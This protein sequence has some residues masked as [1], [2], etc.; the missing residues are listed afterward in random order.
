LEQRFPDL[1]QGDA[2]LGRRQLAQQRLL[3]VQQRL[4]AAADLG[5][6]RA[7]GLA[8][9]P[10]QLDRRRGAHLE[11][12]CRLARRSASFNR[13]NQPAPQVLRQGCRHLSLAA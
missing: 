10:H 1:G 3:P 2:R 8:H 9:T 11:A 4:A 6:R 12:A 13:P 5:R 7:A